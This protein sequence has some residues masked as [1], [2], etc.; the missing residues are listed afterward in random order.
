MGRRPHRPVSQV[1]WPAPGRSFSKEGIM[2]KFIKVWGTVGAVVL[3]VGGITLAAQ[4]GDVGQFT[5]VDGQVEVLKKG[6]PKPVVAQVEAGVAEGD[7]IQTKSLGRAQLKFVDDSTMT[8]APDTNITIESYMYDA[9]KAKRQAVTQVTQGLVHAVASQVQKVAEPDFLIKTP[10]AVMG[11]KGTE[12][13]VLMGRPGPADACEPG[14]ETKLSPGV[15]I[16]STFC[17]VKSGKISAK[18]SSRDIKGETDLT[19]FQGAAIFKGKGVGK[20]VRLTAEDFLVLNAL[21][22][23]GVPARPGNITNPK[24]LLKKMKQFCAPV[25]YTPSSETPPPP[26]VIFPGG[27]GGVGSPPR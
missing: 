21:M 7:T 12:W 19:G 8:L 2:P 9:S 1:G 13:F 27:G 26:P 25:S 6:A 10:T 16:D 11:V 20:P 15:A 14:K 17:F 5:R 23:S 22:A 18:S 3:L 4:A 24:E